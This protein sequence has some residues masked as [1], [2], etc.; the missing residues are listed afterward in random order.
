MISL[1]DQHTRESPFLPDPQEAPGA[2]RLVRVT[3]LDTFAQRRAIDDQ[4]RAAFWTVGLG[5]CDC[6]RSIALGLPGPSS[7]AY[8]SGHCFGFRRFLIIAADPLAPLELAD[9]N[10]HYPAELRALFLPD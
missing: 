4:H 8:S 7:S 10:L 3:I 1:I 9:F 2:R 6:L 5:A